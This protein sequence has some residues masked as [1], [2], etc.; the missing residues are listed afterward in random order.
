MFHNLSKL[1]LIA[2]TLSV[3]SACSSTKTDMMSGNTSG[4]DITN[5]QPTTGGNADISHQ[6]NITPGTLEDYRENI[7]DRVFFETAEYILTSDA[8]NTLQSQ[9]AWLKKHAS[10][11]SVT[12]EGHADERGTRE[13][14]IAL[15]ARRANS[16]RNFL[17]SNGISAAKLNAVSYGK[18]RPAVDGSNPA[19]WAKNRRVVVMPR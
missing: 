1:A 16:V 11:R 4:T 3:V 7:G 13:Y 5:Q 10:G 15:G 19:A 2:A 14:N 8:K 9:A 18:E 17:V 12:I 6:H